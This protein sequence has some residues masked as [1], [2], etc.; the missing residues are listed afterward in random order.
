MGWHYYSQYH[1]KH[2]LQTGL[3]CWPGLINNGVKVLRSEILWRFTHMAIP[4]TF[5]SSTCYDLSEVRDSLVSFINSFG[6]EAA[7]SERG[8]I[9]YHPDLHTHDSCIN[10]IINC[11][12][13]ILIIG[14]RFGGTYIADTKKSIVNAEY[15]AAKELGIPVFT[16]VKQ[17]VMDDHRLYQGNKSKGD[18]FVNNINYPSIDKNEFAQPIFEFI[19]QVKSSNVNNGFFSFQF[20]KDIQAFLKK[21]WAGMFFDFL[22]N[23]L[24]NKKIET[25]TQTLLQLE[26]ASRKIEQL[27]ENIY[28]H[29]DSVKADRAIAL[30]DNKADANNFFAAISSIVNEKYFLVGKSIETI[31]EIDT[32]CKWYDFFINFNEFTVVHDLQ[33]SN[34]RKM[35]F[36][37]HEP[38]RKV[39]A[40][41]GGE[42]TKKENVE[43]QE[44]EKGFNAYKL[45][46]DEQKRELLENYSIPF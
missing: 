36:L 10:E 22:S 19:N 8:D 24:K 1:P 38:S 25:S 9:F 29:V 46:S 14:G 23:R 44:F 34:G 13:F 17:E 40:Y 20:A 4:R 21:Q 7:L 11:Q 18:K 5:I 35:D 16:F 33:E 31:L 37:G 43:F 6:F 42:M 26:T 27:V 30:I 32:N 28:R 3:G 45:L 12:L 15:L 41:V 39:V 2:H